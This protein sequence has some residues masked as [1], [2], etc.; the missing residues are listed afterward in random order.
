MRLVTGLTQLPDEQVDDAPAGSAVRLVL[1]VVVVLSLVNAAIW[2]GLDASPRNRGYEVVAH[3][4]ELARDATA[5]VDLLLIGDSSCNQGIRPEVLGEAIGG[6]ALNLCAIGS[7][8]T[9]HDAYLLAYYL[10]HVG[11]P[12]AIVVVHTWDTWQRDAS[13]LRAMLWK[14][15]VGSAAWA[16]RRPELTLSSRERFNANFG[17]LLPLYSQ[18][19]SVR[20]LL[21]SPRG[22]ERI[23]FLPGGF[24]PMESPGNTA[25]LEGNLSEHVALVEHEA[26]TVSEWSR[27]GIDAT[28]DLAAAAGVP[29]LLASAP[30]YERLAENPSFQ[31][32]EDGYEAFLNELAGRDGVSVLLGRPVPL[33]AEQLEKVDHPNPDGA[34][35]YSRALADALRHTPLEPV[36]PR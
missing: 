35:V 23:E 28:L 8:T 6:T 36:A 21:R 29:V 3:K 11:R 15:P 20:A 18:Q 25:W 31:A 7:A 24:M 17:G 2:F 14:I 22:G 4:W 19:I 12:R 9:A 5:P 1:G 26:F 16:G 13:K 27:S 32:W 30:A 34:A 10:E 33:P